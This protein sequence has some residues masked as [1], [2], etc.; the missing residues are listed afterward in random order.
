MISAFGIAGADAPIPSVLKTVL[1]PL[2]PS[3]VKNNFGRT[4]EGGVTGALLAKRGFK[5]PL[6]ILDGDTGFW[7]AYEGNGPGKCDWDAMIRNLGKDYAIMEVGFKPYPVCRG[8]HS[9][10]DAALEITKG[11]NI[12]PKDIEEVV[13]RCVP[14]FSED[15]PPFNQRE[16]TSMLDV[17]F[18]APYTIALAIY[19]IEPGPSWYSE[20]NLTNPEIRKLAKMVVLVPYGESSKEMFSQPTYR[21]SAVEIK[22]GDKKY[23]RR[24]EF[25]R[26][27]PE[28]PLK[29]QE[30]ENKFR[31][32]ASGVIKKENIEEI[33]KIIRNLETIENVR[34]MTSLLRS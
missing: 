1:A 14:P 31:I 28:N 7:R 2:G 19:G 16:P 10:I 9:P 32:N 13:V 18:S 29:P 26:G 6:D 8:L 5:G 33:I 12:D 30:L 24:I 21:V 17:Q 11:Y 3:M 15:K 25:P 20:G 34:E 22:T 27:E 23:V 4:A